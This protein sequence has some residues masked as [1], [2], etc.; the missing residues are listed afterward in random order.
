M[1]AG[2]ASR[3]KPSTGSSAGVVELDDASDIGDDERRVVEA[4]VPT[5]A[6]RRCAIGSK[7]YEP[8]LSRRGER[9]T[10]LPYQTL[11]RVKPSANGS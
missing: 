2:L 11:N 3:R 7:L 1:C 5:I 6:D 8:R 9:K 4:Y 10:D